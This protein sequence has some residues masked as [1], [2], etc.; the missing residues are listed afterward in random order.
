[1]QHSAETQGTRFQAAPPDCLFGN[2]MAR[3]VKP[4]DSFPE[5]AGSLVVS[6]ELAGPVLAKMDC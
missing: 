1:M 2:T 4:L 3:N 5:N 6:P